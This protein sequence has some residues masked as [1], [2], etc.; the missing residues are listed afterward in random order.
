MAIAIL[1]C[2]CDHPAQDKLHGVGNRVM[3]SVLKGGEGAH[4]CTV[5]GSIVRVN[6]GK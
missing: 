6:K 4:R 5:C 3:N 1:K 2:S